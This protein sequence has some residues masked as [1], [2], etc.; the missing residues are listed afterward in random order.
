V[1]DCAGAW[2]VG[3]L[4]FPVDRLDALAQPVKP[5]TGR[6]GRANAVVHDPDRQL[7]RVGGH[8]DASVLRVRVLDHV[9]QCLGGDVV[10]GQRDSGW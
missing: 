8:L 10:G 3:D 5:G 7:S 9:G 1:Y 2:C 4:Q 6:V